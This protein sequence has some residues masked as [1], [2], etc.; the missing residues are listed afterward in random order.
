MY[1]WEIKHVALLYRCSGWMVVIKV[2]VIMLRRNNCGKNNDKLN[3][4]SMCV[5]RH[6]LST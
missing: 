1:F 2:E 6:E 4:M 5:T 3:R